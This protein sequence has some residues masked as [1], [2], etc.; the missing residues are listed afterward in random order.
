[1]V[2]GKAAAGPAGAATWRPSSVGWTWSPCWPS[3]RPALPPGVAPVNLAKTLEK[4][5]WRGGTHEILAHKGGNVYIYTY[6]HYIHIRIYIYISVCIC[7]FIHMK[8]Q[9]ICITYGMCL[10]NSLA[11][12]HSWIWACWPHGHTVPR[13]LVVMVTD[14]FRWVR[15]GF[16]NP[17]FGVSLLYFYPQKSSKQ[18]ILKANLTS[19]KLT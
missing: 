2:S 10:K 13:C 17:P 4:S 5:P 3:S 12:F 18:H 6:I 11:R 19:G 7:I 9:E 14:F 16:C 8:L 15:M 1:M